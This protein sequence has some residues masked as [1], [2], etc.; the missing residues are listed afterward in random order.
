MAI[1]LEPVVI[2][3]VRGMKA[4]DVRRALEIVKANRAKMLKVWRDTHG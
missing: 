4:A 3:T 1:E 2:Q